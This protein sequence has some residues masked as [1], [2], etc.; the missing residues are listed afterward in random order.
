MATNFPTALDSLTNPTGDQTLASVGHAA[1]HANANDAIEALQAK[2]GIDGSTDHESVDYR[3]SVCESG[4]RAMSKLLLLNSAQTKLTDSQG[5]SEYYGWKDLIGDVT[6]KTAGVGSPTLDVITGNIRGFRY[7]AGDDG[8]ITFH[9]PHD[10]APGTDLYLHPHW[11]HNGTNISGALVVDVYMTYAKGHQQAS[12]HAQK[13]LQITDG[14]LSIGNAPSLHHRIPEIKIS[15]PG[16]STTLL[17]S[18]GLEVDGVL[19]VHYDVS[20][21][22]TITGGSGEPFLLTFDLH[23]QCSTASTKNKAPNFYQ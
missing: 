15:T 18:D 20:A 9:I 2:V 4:D 6:P 17:D 12:F 21:I 1:Q 14:A 5:S 16:G 13:I 19:L 7:S 22:P 8:D 3:L 11:T 10:Y 23:Y